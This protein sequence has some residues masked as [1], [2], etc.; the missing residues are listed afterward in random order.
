MP[1]TLVTLCG[2]QHQLHDA[3]YLQL[4]SALF[5]CRLEEHEKDRLRVVTENDILKQKITAMVAQYEARDNHFNQQVSVH[6]VFCSCIFLLL[7]ATDNHL[8]R[9]QLQTKDIELRMA[10]IKLQEQSE[11]VA[12][13]ELQSQKMS[14]AFHQMQS[15]KLETD[16]LLE[17]YNERF[18]ECQHSIQKSNEVG[19]FCCILWVPFRSA[20]AGS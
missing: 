14:D 15:H 17:S 2:V 13:A 1:H 9:L 18:S 8:T 5:A 16:K 12:R 20:S 11:T 4:I 19:T 3:G 6:K 10:G 7:V